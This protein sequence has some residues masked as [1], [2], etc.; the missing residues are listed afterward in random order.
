MNLAQIDDPLKDTAREIDPATIDDPLKP[1]IDDPLKSPSRLSLAAGVA[2]DMAAKKLDTIAERA[3]GAGEVLAQMV[4][5]LGGSFLGVPAGI[6]RALNPDPNVGGFPEGFRETAEALTYQP[7]TKTGKELS[8]MI[9]TP[10]TFAEKLGPVVAEPVYQK[11]GPVAGVA[12]STAVTAVP[13]V[14]LSLLGIRKTPKVTSG[15]RGAIGAEAIKSGEPIPVLAR[16]DTDLVNTIR[17]DPDAAT[18]I[19]RNE[20]PAVQEVSKGIEE[21]ISTAPGESVPAGGSR[22]GPEPIGGPGLAQRKLAVRGSESPTVTPEH[23]ARLKTDR[24]AFY[25][26]QAEPDVADLVGRMSNDELIAVPMIQEAGQANV[27]SAARLELYKRY[28]AE[29]K[30]DVAWTVFEETMRTGTTMGQLIN[31]LKTLKSATPDGIILA[32]NRRLAKDGYDPVPPV[33]EKILRD[34]GQDSITNHLAWKD[35]ERNWMKNPTDDNLQIVSTARE[36]AIRADVRLQEKVQKYQPRVFWDMMSTLLKGNLLTPISNVAN[37]VGNT[38]NIPLRG[39][40]RNTAAFIDL[41]DASLRSGER[42]STPVPVRGAKEAFRAMARS[43]PESLN[44]LYRGASD[45]ELARVDARTGLHPLRAFRDLIGREAA[46]EGPKRGGKT[47]AGQRWLMALES[48]PF[49]LHAAAQLRTLAA[50][51][52]PFRAAARARLTTEALKLDAMRGGRPYTAAEASRAAKF[53]ELYFDKKTLERIDVEADRAVYL[54]KNPVT[55]AVAGMMNSVSSSTRFL[56]TTIFPYTK[57]PTNVIGEWLSFN[58]AIALTNTIRNAAK[59]NRRLAQYD[60]GKFVMG[61][62]IT[63]TGYYLYEKG[64]LSPSLQDK[65]EQQKGRMLSEDTLPPAHLNLSG[66]A[67]AVKGEDTRWRP[68]DRTVN[69]LRGGGIAG[70]LLMI[71]AD[72]RRRMEK[73]AEPET[74]SQVGLSILTDGMTTTLGYA[75]NQSMLKGSTTLLNAI[76]DNKTDS[77]AAAYFET[78]VSLPLPNTLHAVSRATRE[79]KPEVRGDSIDERLENQLRSRLGVFGLDK[80]LLLKRDL[81][82][83]PIRETPEGN[84]PW[85]YQMMDI[86]KTRTIPQDPMPLHLYTLW[87]RTADNG[88]IPTPPT[89]NLTFK[90]ENYVLNREQLDRLQELVGQ[91]RYRLGTRLVENMNFQKLPEEAQ[92]KFLKKAWAKGGEFGT[93]EF[94]LERIDELK[95]KPK[96]YGYHPITSPEPQE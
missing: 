15:S 61:S 44:A 13:Y 90:R 87:R 73:T 24:A 54:Q 12:V 26:K 85:L 86:S 69:V 52:I 50:F 42:V 72:V 55:T 96:L 34:L 17:N 41:M 21:R 19:A 45:I 91:E 66:I 68:G 27:W 4:T 77:W 29:G 80:N 53:P 51:D 10:F 6:G 78:L 37:I 20:P 33:H 57:T 94:L 81:W 2:R 58:P 71:T 59:G 35:A 84:F 3:V 32:V 56:Y 25:E 1:V 46:I 22:P 43:V 39:Q 60:A 70:A 75:I 31:Q 82:G 63:A 18:A 38:I 49:S 11:F 23:Q 93:K 30:P 47:P 92:I 36:S 76:L 5:G 40:A 79:Y 89:A 9:A 83:R 28:V 7:R 8:A 95:S 74:A 64:L 67:R 62:L 88:V 48:S 14:A 16:T 65:G